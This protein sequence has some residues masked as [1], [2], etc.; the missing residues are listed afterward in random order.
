MLVRKYFILFNV[1]LSIIG[2][3]AHPVY[4]HT[5]IGSGGDVV[6]AY[7]EETRARF[8]ETLNTYR[9]ASNAA[10]ATICQGQG[11]TSVQ[12]DNCALIFSEVASAM[13]DFHTG[14]KRL[15]F[16]LSKDPVMVLGA[17]GALMRVAAKT[18]T[19]P[20][21]SVTFDYALI[22]RRSPKLL[23]ALIAHE[24]G[25]KVAFKHGPKDSSRLYIEDDA[26][27]GEFGS[28][29]AL[30]DA[31]GLA[32]GNFAEAQAIIGAQF[33]IQDKFYCEIR[34]TNGG[35]GFYQAGD[36]FRNFLMSDSDDRPYDV[37]HSGIGP[38]RNLQVGVMQGNTCLS[39]ELM[40]NEGSGCLAPGDIDKRSVDMKVMRLFRPDG[41][42]RTKEP[43]LLA[44]HRIR[45]W[46]PSCEE[47]QA[48]REKPMTIEV[49]GIAF[50][51]TYKGMAAATH[52]A[53]I[54]FE[55]ASKRLSDVCPGI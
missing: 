6:A 34:P 11:L 19:G 21:G 17:D 36:D 35:I 20:E 46:N 32:V 45:G 41:N 14:P 28:G 26:P 33:S 31:L 8:V 25:H 1:A 37:F 24:T 54:P 43:E 50:V 51:C 30:L 12:E 49:E 2:T 44:H 38:S 23:M 29:R 55:T 42:G 48:K 18:L 4:A 22:L 3:C 39:L 5:G 7:L 52:P 10:K 53:L 13:T 40:L 16:E 27:V 15:L 47:D 9:A